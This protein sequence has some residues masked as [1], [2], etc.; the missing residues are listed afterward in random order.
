MAVSYITLVTFRR[1]ARNLALIECPTPI[2]WLF[3]H[4][5]MFAKHRNSNADPPPNLNPGRHRQRSL[6]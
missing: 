3:L 6:T 1:E 2:E 5:V 4:E